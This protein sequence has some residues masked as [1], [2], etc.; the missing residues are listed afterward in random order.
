MQIFKEQPEI[1]KNDRERLEDIGYLDGWNKLVST[2]REHKPSED[3]LKR[4]VILE[5]ESDAPRRQILEKLIVKVQKHERGSINQAIRKHRPK[6]ANW[7]S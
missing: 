6:L 4:L 2:L 5:L 3:D 7:A 1:S